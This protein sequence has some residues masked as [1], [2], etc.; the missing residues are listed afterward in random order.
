MAKLFVNVCLCKWF[1]LLLVYKVFCQSEISYSHIQHAYYQSHCCSYCIN[2]IDL[3]KSWSIAQIYHTHIW[4]SFT[5][6]CRWYD[7]VRGQ[8]IGHAAMNSIGSWYRGSNTDCH[9]TWAPNPALTEYFIQ[10]EL[11][12]QQIYKCM[13]WICQ[14]HL[15]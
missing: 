11:V 4:C 3:Y 2:F 15:W 10:F 8:N 14:L 7:H 13:L 9:R 6:A 1:H 5:T 12:N